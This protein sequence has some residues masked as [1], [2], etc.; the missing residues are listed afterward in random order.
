MPRMR[1]VGRPAE[2]WP[3]YS[4]GGGAAAGRRR[5]GPWP[6]G[7]APWAGRC[8]PAREREGGGMNYRRLMGIDLGIASAH[9]VR[10]LDGEGAVVA[11]RRAWPTAESLAAAETAALAG[12]PDGTRLEGGPGGGGPRTGP[13]ARPPCTRCGSRA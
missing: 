2:A 3:G 7:A 13:P 6:D 5:L 11:K 1:E 12:C 8:D 4:R 10:V 9:T